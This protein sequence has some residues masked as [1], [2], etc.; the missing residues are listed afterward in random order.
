MYQTLRSKSATYPEVHTNPYHRVVSTTSFFISYPE[1]SSSESSK[2]FSPAYKTASRTQH[3]D[4]LDEIHTSSFEIPV[5]QEP[6]TVRFK[7]I[8][9][10]QSQQDPLFEES[11]AEAILDNVR[12][13]FDTRVKETRRSIKK[14]CN[15]AAIAIKYPQSKQACHPAVWF[16]RIKAKLQESSFDGAR[17][18]G[19]ESHEFRKDQPFLGEWTALTCRRKSCQRPT[20]RRD[21]RNWYPGVLQGLHRRATQLCHHSCCASWLG[22]LRLLYQKVAAYA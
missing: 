7:Y 17:Y 14:G 5:F 3:Q 18:N 9:D 16:T 22:V 10:A 2:M 19:A 20:R 6:R 12:E 8:S 1:N 4:S 15:V 21:R 13:S 11:D